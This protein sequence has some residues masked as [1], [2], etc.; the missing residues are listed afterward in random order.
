MIAAIL[1][2]C[3]ASHEAY[4][5]SED[6]RLLPEES[7]IVAR[8]HESRRRSFTTAR[9]CA[10]RA[11]SEL[12]LGSDVILADEHGAPSWP[13]GIVGSITHCA[14][15]RA[16]AVARSEALLC[17]GI[18]AEPNEN[19]PCRV[20]SRLASAEERNAIDE[21]ISLDSST[22][23][24]R[25]LFSAKEAVYKAWYPVTKRPLDFDKIAVRFGSVGSFEARLLVLGPEMPGHCLAGLAG[26]W[27]AENGCD[28]RG[29][30]ATSGRTHG[31]SGFRP[32]H[33][34]V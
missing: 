12:G 19:V 20:L 26:Q 7:G 15:Y 13:A 11:L 10:H 1:P 9:V 17:I 4:D 34:P 18:D 27:I 25:L 32:T 16:A 3:V 30:R 29:Q 8:A 6:G 5:D 31:Q 14:G 2:P 24:D 33:R 23:W 21:L 22:A 28:H